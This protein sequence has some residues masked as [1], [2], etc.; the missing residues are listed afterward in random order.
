MDYEEWFRKETIGILQD[1]LALVAVNGC[2]TKCGARFNPEYGSC[3]GCEHVLF[4][5]QQQDRKET[6]RDLEKR[7]QDLCNMEFKG[8]A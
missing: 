6:I 4:C 3:V 7:I 5:E 2:K 1:M 8:R